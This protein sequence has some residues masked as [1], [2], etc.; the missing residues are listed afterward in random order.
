MS[1]LFDSIWTEILSRNVMRIRSAYTSLATEEQSQVAAHL[2]KM[3]SEEGWHPEQVI[4]A[5]IALEAI[6]HE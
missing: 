2:R 3:V 5:Q 4:S 1:N 6:T